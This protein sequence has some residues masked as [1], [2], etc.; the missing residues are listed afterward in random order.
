MSDSIID[1]PTFKKMYRTKAKYAI[2]AFM[3]IYERNKET[4][5]RPESYR[6]KNNIL[7]TFEMSDKEQNAINGFREIEN[8][9]LQELYDTTDAHH[10]D[11]YESMKNCICANRERE[12]IDKYIAPESSAKNCLHCAHCITYHAPVHDTDF[13]ETKHLCAIGMY[14]PE[15]GVESLSEPLAITGTTDC[16][17]FSD[18]KD[19]YDRLRRNIKALYDAVANLDDIKR[20]ARNNP[21]D[22]YSKL[23][24][25]A[26][27][28]YPGLREELSSCAS[29]M[30]TALSLKRTELK[31]NLT[32]SSFEE[33]KAEFELM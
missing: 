15:E 20:Q 13:Q 11:E 29:K 18:T 21:D 22:P 2:V 23:V 24:E 4:M 3:A 27:E 5:K 28:R 1:T 33:A 25:S 32:E 9:R 17:G 26:L 31:T 19:T 14:D 16:G 7:D 8:T 6:H 30:D 12:L 10:R